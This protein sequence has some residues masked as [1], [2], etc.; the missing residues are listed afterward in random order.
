MSIDPVA[1]LFIFFIFVS[2]VW[3]TWYIKKDEN[4]DKDFDLPGPDDLT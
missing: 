2:A 4:K 1:F 3:F